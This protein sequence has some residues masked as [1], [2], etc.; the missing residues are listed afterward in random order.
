[1]KKIIL[2]LTFAFLL[3]ACCK[4]LQKQEGYE[5]YKENTDWKTRK[6]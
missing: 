3:L 2:F 5:T 4:T 6:L 1:M